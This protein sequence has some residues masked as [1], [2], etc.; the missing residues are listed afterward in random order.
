[1]LHYFKVSI[2]LIQEFKTSFGVQYQRE[3][4][5]LRYYDGEIEAFGEM[6]SDEYPGYSYEFNDAEI[7]VIKKYLAPI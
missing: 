2:P 1:M 4:V 7:I 3:A 6:V 5:I